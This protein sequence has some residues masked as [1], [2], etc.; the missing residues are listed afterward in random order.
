MLFTGIFGGPE[1]LSLYSDSLRVG[2]FGD[3]IP[4][5]ARLFAS[6]QTGPGAHPAPTE[7]V[8]C[9]FPGCEAAGAWR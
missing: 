7:W 8:M 2:R 9:L 5:P 4:V 3:R 6:F 1:Y